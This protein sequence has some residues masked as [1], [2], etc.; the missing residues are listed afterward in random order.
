MLIW[1]AGIGAPL[2]V[3]QDLVTSGEEVL[4]DRNSEGWTALIAASAGGH[5]ETV[6]WLIQQGSN[7]SDTNNAGWTALLAASAHGHCPTVR[8]LIQQGN[9]GVNETV[10]MFYL[11]CPPSVYR[12]R[13]PPSRPSLGQ[14]RPNR[15]AHG[16][17]QWLLGHGPLAR[18]GRGGQCSR[19]R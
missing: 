9:A 10:P 1:A 11:S 8:W 3:V 7:I 16:R 13:N 4:T 6:R 17:L 19:A 5:L 12:N 15:A 18:V 2:N 14:M